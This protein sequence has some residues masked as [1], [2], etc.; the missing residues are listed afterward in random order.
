MFIKKL[1]QIPATNV[2]AGSKTKIQVLINSEQGPH[3]AMRRFVIEPG[4]F[5]PLHN[6]SVEHEQ[7]VLKG[8]AQVRIGDQEFVLTENDV[9]FIPAGMEHSY[10]NIG[11]EPYEFLCM[12]PN[13]E[14]TIKILE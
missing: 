9:V 11:D 12:V 4:G 6:N 2:E 5:M 7:F 13:K 1:D 8:K 14:D 10:K 3:F